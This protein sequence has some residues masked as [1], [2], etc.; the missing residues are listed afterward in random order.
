MKKSELEQIH[1]CVDALAVALAE[2]KHKWTKRE[3]KLY[4][5]AVRIMYAEL[6]W[7]KD[8]VNTATTLDEWLKLEPDV[9]NAWSK[10]WSKTIGG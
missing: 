1:F 7:C 8:G 2:H 6:A 10:A 5:K 3:R 4:D 9:R